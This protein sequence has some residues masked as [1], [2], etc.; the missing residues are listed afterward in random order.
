MSVLQCDR[1]GCENIMCDNMIDGRYICYQ[2]LHEL[3]HVHRPFSSISKF[4]ANERKEDYRNEWIN[5]INEKLENKY[6]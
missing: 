2:C 5:H 1:N 6:E 4:F 3:K